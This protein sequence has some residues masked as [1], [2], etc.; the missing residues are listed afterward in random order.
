MLDICGLKN[1]HFGGAKINYN[2]PLVIINATGKAK[3]TT[4][5]ALK[6]MGNEIDD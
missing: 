3:K 6:D 5:Q 1:M 2:Q 4:G